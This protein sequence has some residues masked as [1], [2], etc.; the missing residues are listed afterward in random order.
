MT[1]LLPPT[2][3]TGFGSLCVTRVLTRVLLSSPTF[4]KHLV[5]PHCGP[6]VWLINRPL[7][8]RG[9][10]PTPTGV[11][12]CDTGPGNSS[13]G[14]R[15]GVNLSMRP[16]LASPWTLAGAASA[17]LKHASDRARIGSHAPTNRHAV[18]RHLRKLT[19]GTDPFRPGC[20]GPGGGKEEQ[21]SLHGDRRTAQMFL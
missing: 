13:I 11:A 4:F 20:R 15:R 18:S 7:A 17:G 14:W 9:R 5:A 12:F 19:N 21:F 3:R 2:P 10:V 16:P 1:S 8:V 6:A